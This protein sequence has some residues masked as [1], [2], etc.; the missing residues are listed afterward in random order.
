MILQILML[1]L[2]IIFR[3][4]IFLQKFLQT[5]IATLMLLNAKVS[6]LNDSLIQME[7]Y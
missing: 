3:E 4:T 7:F 1:F 2:E 5:V 6:K